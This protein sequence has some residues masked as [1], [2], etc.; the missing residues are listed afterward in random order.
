[1]WYG[2]AA[3][4]VVAVHFAYIAYVVAGQLAITVAAPFRWQWARN[5]WFRFTH[6]A[7]IGYVVYEALYSIRCPLTIWEEKLRGLAGQGFDD[8]DTFLGRLLHD[9][10]FVQNMPEVWHTTVYIAMFALVVQGL[11]M[12][13]PR[14]FRFGRREKPQLAPAA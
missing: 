10:I 11:V 7:A 6:L 9:T 4:L 2:L 8:S 5:P 3:D 1:M 12:Y 14:W 13:P